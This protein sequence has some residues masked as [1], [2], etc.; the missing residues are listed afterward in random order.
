METGFPTNWNSC[1]G[2]PNCSHSPTTPPLAFGVWPLHT[3]LNHSNA[4]ASSLAVSHSL[5]YP[6][7]PPTPLPLSHLVATRGVW[8]TTNV[9]AR[10]S[11]AGARSRE[12]GG[13]GSS[14]RESAVWVGG[15]WP[16]PAR[17]PCVMG[18]PRPPS[19]EEGER[20]EEGG[21]GDVEHQERGG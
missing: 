12:V 21:D 14:W 3:W 19:V 16:P 17:L 13:V 2:S 7:A 8:R 18:A 9:V 1:I 15:W 10:P 5:V 11:L 4:T 6:L 20:L